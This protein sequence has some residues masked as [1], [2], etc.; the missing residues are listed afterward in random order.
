MQNVSFENWK[1]IVEED[2]A[3]LQFSTEWCGP[4][5][6]QK[7]IIGEIEKTNHN[8]IVFG[9]IDIEEEYDLAQDF[10]VQSVPTII[11]LNKGKETARLIG[12][13]SECDLKGLMAV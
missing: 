4:C 7:K 10:N 6:K 13:Q 9:Q 5:K 1:Q 12:M 2:R 8:K 11:V 3:I